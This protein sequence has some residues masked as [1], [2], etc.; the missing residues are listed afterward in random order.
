MMNFNYEEDA[1]A[2]QR[3]I[4]L[5]RLLDLD[6]Y[7]VG[8]TL[9]ISENCQEMIKACG[10]EK[11]LALY[12]LSQKDS[13]TCCVKL[14]KS[15]DF[16]GFV[17]QDSVQKCINQYKTGNV[18]IE[19]IYSL[20]ACEDILDRINGETLIAPIYI[21]AEECL[22]VLEVN[23]LFSESCRSYINIE[24]KN[25]GTK[26][27]P[28]YIGITNYG[29]IKFNKEL[30][31]NMTPC[32]FQETLDLYS[33]TLLQEIYRN[34]VL[35]TD[36][37]IPRLED[38]YETVIKNI[39]TVDNLKSLNEKLQEKVKQQSQRILELLNEK[40][41]NIDQ[42]IKEE[43][44]SLE[45]VC[46]NTGADETQ[47][48][49][50]RAPAQQSTEVLRGCAPLTSRATNNKEEVNI[51][52]PTLRRPPSR[53]TRP[54]PPRKYIIPRRLSLKSEEPVPPRKD[55][56]PRRPSKVPA[57]NIIEMGLEVA[58]RIITNN[59]EL[60]KNLAEEFK[61]ACEETSKEQYQE[62]MNKLLKEIHQHAQTKEELKASINTE[63]NKLDNLTT[64]NSP[65]DVNTSKPD[66]DR[67]L[68]ETPKV[69]LTDIIKDTMNK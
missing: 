9:E 53:S 48:V 55:V 20:N 42:Q 6:A 46:E 45:S 65:S 22:R 14:N 60:S 17:I 63:L 11:E 69:Y 61:T 59:P 41:T 10:L 7:K 49:S 31:E 36:I 39:N 5:R 51:D 58:D 57:E 28:V 13:N 47:P 52:M 44:E 4:Q 33:K 37:K 62:D 40:K 24:L 16:V 64:I 29:F 2:Y 68:E 34:K 23:S 43:N 54:V 15:T 21:R 8:K 27:N 35:G 12:I 56:I 30:L 38:C 1:E 26:V 19:D 3:Q 67:F 25:H 18:I 50:R 66:A 32:I